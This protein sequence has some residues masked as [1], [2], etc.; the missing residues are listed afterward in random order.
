M[1]KRLVYTV[2][3]VLGLS[4]AVS[5]H[6]DARHYNPKT[7]FENEPCAVEAEGGLQQK[8]NIETR[9]LLEFSPI[10]QVVSFI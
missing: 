5:S 1:K 2:L 8:K 4:A 9:E 7:H 6:E 3:L 10:Y